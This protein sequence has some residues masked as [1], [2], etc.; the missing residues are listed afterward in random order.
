MSHV[1]PL[2]R[3]VCPETPRACPPAGGHPRSGDGLTAARDA[4]I[5]QGIDVLTVEA[6]VG[7]AADAARLVAQVEHRFGRLDLLVTNAGIIQVGA[8]ADMRAQDHA[9][10]MDIMFWGT[11]HTVRPRYRCCGTGMA[12]C[13]R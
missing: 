5:Q 9:Q 8:A 11:L 2:P 13:S 1:Y 10:A 12:G 3:P 4:L 7:D 6:D